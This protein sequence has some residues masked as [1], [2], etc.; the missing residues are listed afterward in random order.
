MNRHDMMRKDS[1]R[2]DAE[3]NAAGGAGLETRN[4]QTTRREADRGA[5]PLPGRVSPRPAPAGPAPASPETSSEPPALRLTPRAE[6]ETEARPAIDDEAGVPIDDQGGLGDQYD[7][8][9]DHDDR[10]GAIGLMDPASP[11]R[12]STDPI[13]AELRA[14]IGDEPCRR[15]FGR[16]ASIKIADGALRITVPSRFLAGQIE[17]RFGGQLREVLGTPPDG[18]P[19]LHLQLL[20]DR[21]AFESARVEPVDPRSS[22]RSAATEPRIFRSHRGPRYDFDTFIVGPENRLAHSASYGVARG[23]HRLSPLF[24]HG[25]CGLGKTHL[26]QSVANRYRREHPGAQVRCLTAESFTNDFITATRTGTLDQFRARYRGVDM[27]CIDDVHFLAS[28]TGTQNELL[29]TFDAIGMSGKLVA[30]A[31][32]EHPRAI[33]RLSAALVSRFMSGAVVKL[34]A[35]GE[36]LRLELLSAFAE[37]RGLTLEPAALQMLSDRAARSAGAVG[38]SVRDIEALVNQVGA[39]Y[40][41][42]PEL[43]GGGQDGRIGATLAAR[44]LGLTESSQGACAHRPMRIQAVIERCCAALGVGHDEFIG[45]GRHKRVVLTRALTVMLARELTNHSYPEIARAMGR[46]NHSTVI[47]AFKRIEQQIASGERVSLGPDQV[48]IDV[49]DLAARIRRELTE[50]AG[51]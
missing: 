2:T 45:R 26:L 9:G 28:K 5:R 49:R 44:A 18:G 15:Y 30:L 40:R 36:A 35:P 43:H 47:T 51:K 39:A 29:H 21:E 4:Q 32:D 34:D 25:S 20:V 22:H 48:E 10:D 11:V 31:S 46:P 27:L 6:P 33:S 7:G 50:I 3:G 14:R 17:R 24:I 38:A 13:L 12:R 37:R 41:L 19:A 1:L 8:A 16:M 42:L 23:D